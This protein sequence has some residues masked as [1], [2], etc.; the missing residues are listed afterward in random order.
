MRF[1][2]RPSKGHRACA[3]P[4]KCS[5]IMSTR[6]SDG[7]RQPKYLSLFVGHLDLG[8]AKPEAE[9]VFLLA[10]E[11]KVG[12][13]GA[14]ASLVVALVCRTI[15]RGHRTPARTGPVSSPGPSS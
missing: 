11:D 3:S 2:Q 13:L 5:S 7:V 1:R 12:V 9:G 10:S 14:P 4:R 15:L 6:S 8:V